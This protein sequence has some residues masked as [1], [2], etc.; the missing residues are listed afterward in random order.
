MIKHLTAL[1]GIICLTPIVQADPIIWEPADGGNGNGYE[2]IFLE[3]TISWED[4]AAAAE[5]MGGYLVSLTTVAENEFVAGL[6]G[7]APGLLDSYWL[8]GYQTDPNGLG[9]PDGSWAWV[10]GEYW[11][12]LFAADR[13][14]PDEPNNADGIQHY[15][16]F[17]PSLPLWDDMDNR[18]TMMGYV[19]EYRAVPEPGTLA[20][21]GIGLLAM[22][23]TGRRRLVH[24]RQ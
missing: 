19:V 18:N 10:S 3:T 6:I 17:W 2:V 12:P 14:A 15:L 7:A 9:E 8:G 13:W 24:Q 4:A 22:G 20:L 5:A 23:F 11:D 21:L 16:H 1:F